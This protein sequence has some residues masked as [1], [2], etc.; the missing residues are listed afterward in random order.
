MTEVIKYNNSPIG[1]LISGDESAPFSVYFPELRIFFFLLSF[2]LVFF[3]LLLDLR[4]QRISP[5]WISDESRRD[6]SKLRQRLESRR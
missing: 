4:K 5:E 6:P 3:L 1:L 2:G